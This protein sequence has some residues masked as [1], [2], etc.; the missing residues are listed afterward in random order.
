[1]LLV[2]F[3]WHEFSDKLS[4]KQYEENIYCIS[5]KP[6]EII[7]NKVWDPIIIYFLVI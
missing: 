3:Y 1:M 5:F 6:Y 2:D 4:H 7:P